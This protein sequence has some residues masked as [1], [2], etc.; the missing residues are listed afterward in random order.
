MLHHTSRPCYAALFTIAIWRATCHRSVGSTGRLQWATYHTEQSC[1]AWFKQF[2]LFHGKRHPQDMGP[3]EVR[4]NS[5]S[6]TRPS[7]PND[8]RLY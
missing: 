4:A 3:T 6:L 7:A 8:F 2:I 5:A 1:V